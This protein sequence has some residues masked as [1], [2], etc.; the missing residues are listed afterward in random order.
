MNRLRPRLCLAWR[1][2]RVIVHLLAGLATCALVFPWAT[3]R[4]RDAATRRWS[5]R[6]LAICNVRVEAAAGDPAA[7]DPAPGDPAAGDPAAGDPAAGDPAPGDPA[8]GDPAPGV[9]ALEHALFVA[10]HIS[11][12]D[13]FVINSLYP[14]R[15]VAKAEI[16][17]WP[18]LGWLAAAAG[19]IFIA[20]GDRRELRHIFKGI[21]A[22]LEQGE[23]VAFFPEGTVARQGTVLPFHA[24][25]FEAAVDARVAVQPCALAYLDAAG[26]WHGGVDYTGDVSFA[27]SIVTILKGAPVRARLA[28][29]APLAGAGAHRRE[30]AQAAHDA[31]QAAL[32]PPARAAESVPVLAPLPGL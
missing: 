27:D 28:C 8:A 18:V 20:R 14:C 6:L 4:L 13:I 32:S 16:R 21:V 15:F 25:L 31:I 3:R 23:R 26:N 7:G 1:L 29:L 17:A 24:N 5:R 30:L 19:T 10:N 22:V 11:W 2:A 12:L 9:P